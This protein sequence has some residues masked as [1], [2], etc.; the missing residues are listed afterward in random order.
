MEVPSW[1]PVVGAAAAFAGSRP[2]KR[3]KADPRNTSRRRRDWPRAGRGSFLREEPKRCFE[4][5]FFIEL[6]YP[7]RRE[8]VAAE[9]TAGAAQPGHYGAEGDLEL[10]GDFFVREFF[11][12]GE[13]EDLAVGGRQLGEGAGEVEIGQG[14]R[15]NEMFDRMVRRPAAALVAG[16]VKKDAEEP[17]AEV[18]AGFKAGELP[19]SDEKGVLE[20]VFGGDLVTNEPDGGAEQGGLMAEGFDGEVVRKAQGVHVAKFASGWNKV[21]F[22]R[23]IGS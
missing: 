2:A 16:A 8:V 6:L 13:L 19:P 1:S 23:K 7:L 20:K 14:W 12:V 17:G 3:P 4:K 11:E 5:N 21:T 22:K 15:R 18:G 10:I 9:E